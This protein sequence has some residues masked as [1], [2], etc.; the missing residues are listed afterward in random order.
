MDGGHQSQGAGFVGE[1]RGDSRSSFH[2]L[3][4]ETLRVGTFNLRQSMLIQDL[5]WPLL[6]TI[7]AR[8]AIDEIRRQHTEGRDPAREVHVPNI[9]ESIAEATIHNRS[10]G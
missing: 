9:Q 1:E 3:V 8:K 5:V 4:D 6:L 7:T 2:L 10:G